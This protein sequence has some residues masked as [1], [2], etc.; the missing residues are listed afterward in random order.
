MSRIGRRSRQC[1]RYW[2]DLMKHKSR[3]HKEHGEHKGISVGNTIN[4]YSVV[5]VF[6][7]AKFL[8]P[9]G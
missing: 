5:F 6:F 1:C 7:V 9:T 8:L 2:T 4:I 3:S